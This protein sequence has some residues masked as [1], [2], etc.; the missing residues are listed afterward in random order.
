MNKYE[1]FME[2]AITAFS[3]IVFADSKSKATY[4]AFQKWKGKELSSNITFNQF[5]KWF[6]NKTVQLN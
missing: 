4:K 5:L 3:T 6:Y 2:T 1:V